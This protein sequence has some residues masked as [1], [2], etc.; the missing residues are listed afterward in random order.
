VTQWQSWHDGYNDR[1]SDLSQ[2]LAVI[3]RLIRTWADQAPPGALRIISICAGQAHDVA[4]ALG[5]HPRRHDLTGVLVE[6][7]EENAA[8]A[9][10]ALHEAGLS[11]LSVVVDD[12][13]R[14]TAYSAAVPTNLLLVCGV[15]G[16]ISDSDV[17]RTI[18]AL[19]MLVAHGATVVWTRHRRVPDLTTDIRRW[20]QASRFTELSFTSP[21]PDRFAVGS[22]RFEGVPPVFQPASS[23]LFT[24]E[25]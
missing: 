17:E 13:A 3:Q 11:G 5:G 22:H 23:A 8:A 9:Q 1:R 7:D 20:F 14:F 19:P 15:F 12:A 10:G 25:R 4:G 21:G 2:R 18:M 24:F 6:L 16:N